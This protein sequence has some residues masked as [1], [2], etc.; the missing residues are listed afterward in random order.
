MTVFAT[1]AYRTRTM[2]MVAV[3]GVTLHCFTVENFTFVAYLF[4]KIYVRVYYNL[5][6]NYPYKM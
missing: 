5:S 4:V 2:L 1:D 6:F 3:D